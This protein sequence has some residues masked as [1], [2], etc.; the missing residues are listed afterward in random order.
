MHAHTLTPNTNCNSSVSLNRKL[1]RQKF[2]FWLINSERERETDRDRQ[3]ETE[4]QNVR[5]GSALPY[6]IYIILKA[7][8]PIVL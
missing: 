1:A 5:S 6:G 3:R 4:T 7:K 2:N 8:S